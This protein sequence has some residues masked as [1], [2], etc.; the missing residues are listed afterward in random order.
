MSYR[1]I[2]TDDSVGQSMVIYMEATSMATFLKKTS[3]N[4]RD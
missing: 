1:N 4:L 3:F 2:A